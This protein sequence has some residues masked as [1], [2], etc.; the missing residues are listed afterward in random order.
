MATAFRDNLLTLYPEAAG[1]A[2]RNPRKIPQSGTKGVTH[3]KSV[4]VKGRTYFYWQALYKDPK[5][6]KRVSMKFSI[7]KYGNEKALD[8]AKRAMPQ[9]K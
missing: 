8:L 2:Q 5:I 7:T 9:A 1:R 4:S 6:R 3:V